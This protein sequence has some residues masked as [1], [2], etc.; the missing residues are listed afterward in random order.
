MEKSHAGNPDLIGLEYGL[1]MGSF[2]N[3]LGD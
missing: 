3:F 2:K 1:G